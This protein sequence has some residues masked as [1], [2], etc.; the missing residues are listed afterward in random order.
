LHCVM[1]SCAT[2]MQ[3]LSSTINKWPGSPHRLGVGCSQELTFVGERLL[4]RQ[5]LRDTGCLE[6]DLLLTQ[7][8]SNHKTT[9]Q[10]ADPSKLGSKQIWQCSHC[11]AKTVDGTRRPNHEE[12]ALLG[13]RR[14]R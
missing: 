6:V 8:I 3:S 1:R 14:G 9:R 2:I 7:V 5:T 10:Y 13:T 12:E 11:P 4:Y